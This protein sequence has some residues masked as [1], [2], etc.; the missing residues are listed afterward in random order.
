MRPNPEPGTLDGCEGAALWM[1]EIVDDSG[2]VTVVEGVGGEVV[3]E[4]VV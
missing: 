4:L 2:V 1:D 3:D